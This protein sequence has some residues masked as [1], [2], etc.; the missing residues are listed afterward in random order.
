MTDEF[1]GALRERVSFEQKLA[2]RDALAATTGRYRYNGAAWAAVTPIG[3]GDAVAADA[4]SALPRW[5]V[6]IRK[7]DDIDLATRLIWRGRYL[8]VRSIECDPRERAH[9]VLVTEEQR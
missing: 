6:M 4:L 3:V 2:E 1:S 5:R 9:M 8:H 7:R